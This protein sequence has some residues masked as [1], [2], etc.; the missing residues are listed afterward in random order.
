MTEGNKASKNRNAKINI[1]LHICL[2]IPDEKFGE[3]KM[4]FKKSNKI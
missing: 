2:Q 4:F 3:K 1:L